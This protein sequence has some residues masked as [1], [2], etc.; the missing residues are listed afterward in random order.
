V[1]DVK[2][3][4]EGMTCEHCQKR[5]HDAI[6]ALDGVTSLNVDLDT[7]EATISYDSSR[8][9]VDQIKQAVRD[10]DYQ[11]VD[12]GEVCPVPTPDGMKLMTE[13]MV[14]MPIGNEAKGTTSPSEIELEP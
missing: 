12:E 2:I 8:I 1:E 4:V 11:V 13:D 5:V 6:A 3:K 10:A 7:G 9:E 14:S